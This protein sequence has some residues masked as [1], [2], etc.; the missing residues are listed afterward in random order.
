MQGDVIGDCRG[1]GALAGRVRLWP[2]KVA[3]YAL[4]GLLA[5]LFLFTGRVFA[6]E[7]PPPMI[8]AGVSS[9]LERGSVRVIVDFYLPS[10]FKPEGSLSPEAVRLQRE[11]IRSVQEKVDEHLRAAGVRPGRRFSSVPAMSMTIDA[12]ALDVLRE[13]GDLVKSVRLDASLR[14]QEASP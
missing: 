6:G 12:E 10:G 11:A 7:P 9:A 5:I 1:A 3:E 14:P 13:M 2:K 8:D 4:V